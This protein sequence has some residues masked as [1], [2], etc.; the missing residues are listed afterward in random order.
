MSEL[1]YEVFFEGKKHI[2]SSCDGLN[3]LFGYIDNGVFHITG[4]EKFL[5]GN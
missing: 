1:Y 3:Y 4:E 2:G 5:E